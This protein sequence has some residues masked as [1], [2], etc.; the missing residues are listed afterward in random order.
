V[1]ETRLQGI[2]VSSG[3]VLAPLF[4]LPDLSVAQ[5]QAGGPAEE[6]AALESALAAAQQALE[7]L[8]EKEEGEAAD[9]LEFQVVLL[10]DEDILTPV[11]AAIEA[12]SVAQDAWR[13]VLEREIAEYASGD[14]GDEVFAARAS[15]LA[16]LR[17]RVL[18]GLYGPAA[19]TLLP[20]EPSILIARDLPP[21]RFLEFDAGLLAGVALGEGSRTS[22]VSLLARARGLPLVVGLGDL[23]AGLLSGQAVLDAARGCLVLDPS[24]ATLRQARENAGQQAARDKRAAELAKEPAFTAQ[25]ERVAVMVNVDH[26]SLLDSLAVE[27]CDGVGL[28]RTEFLFQE[29]APGEEEQLRSYSALLRWAA[30]RPVTIRTLDAGGDKPI[31]GVTREG[32]S[33]PFLGLRGL[34]LSLAEPALFKVQLRA[35]LRA[36]AEGPL[37]IMVPMVTEPAE[38]ARVKALLAEAAAELETEGL[39]QGKPALGMMIEVPV[40][41]LTAEDFDVDFYSIG[42]NDLVQ[43]ATACARDNGAVAPLAKG[44]NPGV[45]KLIEAVVAAG[46]ARGVEVSVCGDMASDPGDA[47]L[48]LAAGVRSLSVAAAE[49]GRIKA[50]VAE[51]RSGEEV[52]E[53]AESRI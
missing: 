4:T 40:A 12:G 47:R 9:I 15:D 30:G 26:P 2:G 50:A 53:G 21:S 24:E 14:P 46:K 52:E 34:R 32:E 6:R 44:D 35:L 3:V 38:I 48:L 20:R 36:A 18:A 31:A 49:V 16:D 29:G 43:Y 42:T 23:P 19:R 39:A 51:F 45:L 10:E 13:A 37:K 33:N 41:A 22:H 27:T 8:M 25:G 7:A 11:F 5:R 17:D 28:T 1:T